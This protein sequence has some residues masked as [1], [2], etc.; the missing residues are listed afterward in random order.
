MS[1]D[2]WSNPA[3][4]STPKAP[5]ATGTIPA[6]A[7][8]ICNALRD[9]APDPLGKGE[10]CGGDM[11]VVVVPLQLRLLIPRRRLLQTS[12]RPELGAAALAGPR[13][14]HEAA[15]IG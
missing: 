2:V 10:G 15:D 8:T 5:A 12:R 11:G 3:P 13:E 9:E 1:S 6:T 14:R 4:R 7:T